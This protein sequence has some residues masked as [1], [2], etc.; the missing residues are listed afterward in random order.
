MN[1]VPSLDEL[2]VLRQSL[3]RIP[4]LDF[5]LP[6]TIAF[7]TS[8]LRE[9]PCEVIEPCVST[10][11]AY[12]DIDG[13]VGDT[14]GTRTTLA[15]RADMDALPITEASDAEF[16]SQHPGKMHACGHDGHM[17][18]ALGCAWWL[19]SLIKAGQA[20]QVKHNV[21]FVFQPA[22]ETTGGAKLVCESGVFER[23][24][25]S[26]IF[27]FHV[28]PDLP[29]GVVATRSGALL[30]RSSETT[31]TIHG[32]A[33]HI[34]KSEEGHDALH[35]GALFVIDALDAMNALSE[36]AGEPA[37]LR[38]GH[39]TSGSVRNAISDNTVIEGS[40]RV[41]SDEM[42]E[43]AKATIN[44]SATDN[45]GLYGCSYDLHF[46]E[47]YPPVIND[48]TLTYLARE[49]LAKA[50]I[51]V[52][53]IDKPLLIAED[54]AFYQKHLPG[55][56]FLLGTG[57]GIPLHSDKFNFDEEILLKGVEVYKALLAQ[58]N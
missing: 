36:Q 19:G 52:A 35:A 49:T 38:F 17:S 2:R 1:C 14:A 25:V 28:W 31:I 51:D 27:G 8:I 37:L 53:D 57:T 50:G 30:A 41:F 58:T 11:C 34:A 32:K 3:H 47:G 20:A 33:S 15:I 43:R 56:F 24:N 55:T 48:D 22:E 9:L 7:V 26:G 18:M 40:L 12:F 6:K 44:E 16:A 29:A 13:A 39:M 5:E 46:S 54:F 21:L 10:V 4:E 23:Y 45:C 42:F